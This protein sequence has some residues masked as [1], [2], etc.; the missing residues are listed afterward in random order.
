MWMVYDEKDQ[1]G[2]LNPQDP[3]SNEH[4]HTKDTHK[5]YD[6]QHKDKQTYN[7]KEKKKMEKEKEGGS[8]FDHFSCILW[9]RSKLFV[10]KW[11][12]SRATKLQAVC[13]VSIQ[14][15]ETHMHTM[16]IC[17]H[18]H[19]KVAMGKSCLSSTPIH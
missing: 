7:V 16:S 6:M 11:A 18:T 14:K 12:H 13:I 9:I 1:G 3:T 4:K 8:R 17:T 15:G 2:W 5:V 10:Q 19:K